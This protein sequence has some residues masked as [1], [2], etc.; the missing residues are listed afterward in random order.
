MLGAIQM[1]HLLRYMT[2]EGYE[3]VLKML[4]VVSP[5]FFSVQY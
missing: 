5:V 2:E 4:A 3:Q 1:A